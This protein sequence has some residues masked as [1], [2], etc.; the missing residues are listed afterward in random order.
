[1]SE[2][3]II[4]LLAN[5]NFKEAKDLI[6]KLLKVDSQ[7]QKYNFYY[8]ILLAQEK[9]FNDAIKFFKIFLEKNSDDYDANFNI[10]NCYL[11]L[12]NFE[13]AIEHYKICTNLVI[14]RHEPFHQLGYCFKLI[15]EYEK[16]ILSL[17]K[18]I[19]IKPN[20]NSYYILAKVYRENGQFAESKKS[21][22]LS[23]TQDCNFINSKL[24]LADLENDLGLHDKASEM[25]SEIIFLYKNDNH[26]LSKAYIIKGNILKSKGNYKSAIE[27]NRKA[28]EKDPR[29]IEAMYNLSLNYL[30]IKDY[31][32]AW[33]FY[34]SRYNLQSFVLLKKI[35][36]TF[37]KPRWDKNKPQKKILFYGEQGI[38]EQILYSQ[39]ISVIQDQFE[40][41]TLAVNQKLVPFFKKIFNNI[42]VI[43]YRNIYQHDD[44]DFHFPMGSLGL[45]FQNEINNKILKKKIDYLVNNDFIPKKIKKIRCGISWKSTNK[46]FGN[47][48]SVEL[49]L[50]KELF[51]SNNIEFI[52]LQY[53]NEDYDIEKLEK[54]INKKLFVDHNIDCFNDI[55]GVAS[56][57]KSCDFI[58]TVSN[59]NA[60]IS[61][62]LGV[63][64]FLLLTFNDGKL[65][66]WGQNKDAD[67]IWYPSILPIRMNEENN[68]NSCILKLNKEL[69]NIL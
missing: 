5:K 7:N 37:K 8:G 65:W 57:I 34:E 13:K 1:M 47:K 19:K 22:Q 33:K 21:L 42:K 23:I 60:H 62:K 45:F 32:N 39:F 3:K 61:G 58:V 55:D 27:S 49:G 10:A 38:G 4:D 20:P 18:A 68:W 40:N 56:L 9:K 54:E 44:Y 51:L 2:K 24:S 15:R 25:I 11:V 29:N 16:S 64:T 59:S 36:N 53:S 52:N 48:K 66:Y 17:I 67:I 12:L 14:D 6:F 31:P 30:F 43:D 28:L 35:H 69:E 63:K 46:I 50:F 41:I 26:V